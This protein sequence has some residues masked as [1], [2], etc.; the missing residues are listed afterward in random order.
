[1]ISDL[2]FGVL[3]PLMSRCPGPR[4]KLPQL[5][6]RSLDIRKSSEISQDEWESGR[7][8]AIWYVVE[9]YSRTGHRHA[10]RWAGDR[11][12]DEHSRGIVRVF[13]TSR[14]ASR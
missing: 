6:S 14:L 13:P 11:L 2:M 10:V 8:Y 12:Y 4:A 7:A 9:L 3:A 5:T 1:M